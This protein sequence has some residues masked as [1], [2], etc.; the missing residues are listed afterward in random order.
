MGLSRL[1][2]RLQEEREEKNGSSAAH[3]FY[4]DNRII[5]VRVSIHKTNICILVRDLFRRRFVFIVCL[6]L[7]SYFFFLISV[8]SA[9][10]CFFHFIFVSFGL[11][12]LKFYFYLNT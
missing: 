1:E 4:S 5:Y 9:R 10:L 8:F 12:L 3:C 2:L 6:D 11:D 7:S